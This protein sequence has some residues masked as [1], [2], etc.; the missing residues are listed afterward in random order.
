TERGQRL[1]RDGVDGVRADQ[2]LDVV[3]VGVARVFGRRARPPL[4]R[5][6]RTCLLQLLPAR[7]AEQ[8]HEVLVCNLRVGDGGLA[9][10]TLERLLL[11]RLYGRADHRGEHF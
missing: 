4:P 1:G 2:L 8:L 5:V 9:V 11:A 3:R 10:Q 7:A 6:A